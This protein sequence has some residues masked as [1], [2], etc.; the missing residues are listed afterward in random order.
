MKLKS[1]L[2]INPVFFEGKTFDSLKNC[3][4]LFFKKE[5]GGSNERLLFSP[6]EVRGVE[7]RLD[8]R[9]RK[10]DPPQKKF[11][12]TIVTISGVV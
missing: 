1:H 7:V 9:V 4:F 3:P 12:K 11:F 2:I 6:I 10:A 5:F 8:V